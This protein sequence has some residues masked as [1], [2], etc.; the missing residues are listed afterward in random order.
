MRRWTTDVGADVEGNVSHRHHYVI[1]RGDFHRQAI[2][3]DEARD[4]VRIP[5]ELDGG[6]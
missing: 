5:N 3:E 6:R 4:A 2:R 1:T